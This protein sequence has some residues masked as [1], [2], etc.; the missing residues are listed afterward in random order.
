MSPCA[1]PFR[2]LVQRERRVPFSFMTRRSQFLRRERRPRRPRVLALRGAINIGTSHRA[3]SAPRVQLAISLARFSGGPD[4][5][6][7]AAS[8]LC[9]LLGREVYGEAAEGFELFQACRHYCRGRDADHGNHDPP[10][11]RRRKHERILSP[12]PPPWNVYRPFLG[13]KFGEIDD[14]A[15]T[16]HGAVTRSFSA[17]IRCRITPSARLNL[18]S[19]SRR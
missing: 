17:L 7:S 16:Q 13:G 8:A 4:H 18:E 12:R 6:Q 3:S 10:A 5:G 15:R 19:G 2:P 1:R 9:G 11:Q 14:F